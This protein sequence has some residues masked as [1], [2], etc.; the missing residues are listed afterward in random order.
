MTSDTNIRC[1]VKKPQS[2]L[3]INETPRVVAMIT[4][5]QTDSPMKEMNKAMVK[6]TFEKYEEHEEMNVTPIDRNMQHVEEESKQKLVT[7]KRQENGLDKADRPKSAFN[8][9][10]NP[11]TLTQLPPEEPS[12]NHDV[13]DT[14]SPTSS[15]I[16][17]LK[18]KI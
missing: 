16:R 8:A 13:D 5:H 2:A 9:H 6:G 12:K 3:E 1:T 14:P 4:T 10:E 11:H 7:N 17:S 18:N 15:P